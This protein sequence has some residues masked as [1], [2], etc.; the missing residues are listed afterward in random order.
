[1]FMLSSGFSPSGI[2]CK[3]S[4]SELQENEVF[5]VPSVELA[6]IP[7]FDKCSFT[8]IPQ[9]STIDGGIELELKIDTCPLLFLLSKS[10]PSSTMLLKTSPSSNCGVSQLVIALVTPILDWLAGSEG[11]LS[12]F[13][14][15]PRTVLIACSRVGFAADAVGITTPINI[16]AIRK[17]DTYFQW[18]VKVLTITEAGKGIIKASMDNLV[19]HCS[20]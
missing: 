8:L 10:S 15:M 20:A 3:Y 17:K 12:T 5:I 1:M 14:F 7:V 2:S 11:S 18:M 16:A 9:Y 6:M 13:A 4:K 19:G